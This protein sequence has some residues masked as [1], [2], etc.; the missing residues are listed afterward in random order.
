[1]AL[2]TTV[3]S[4]KLQVLWPWVCPIHAKKLVCLSLHIQHSLTR[5]HLSRAPF[6]ATLQVKLTVKNALAFLA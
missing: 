1:M 4:I 3:K 2:I 5:S 6:E